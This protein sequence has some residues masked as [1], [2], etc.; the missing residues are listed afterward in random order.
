VKP[1]TPLI[2]ATGERVMAP[3]DRLKALEVAMANLQ[4]KF[5]AD[6]PEVKKAHREITELR[7]MVMQTGGRAAIRRQKI[8]QL[9]AN[10]AEKQ[11][12][13]SAQH[14]EVK[15]LQNEIARLEPYQGTASPRPVA[16]P[17][18]PAYISL[19]TYIKAA[20]NE[21]VSLRTQQAGLKEKLRL[22]RQR[23][24]DAGIIKM[25]PPSTRRS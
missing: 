3:A 15:Q 24:E 9:Q 13:Y 16:E 22:Y 18:N 2:G 1:D 25:P 10:L 5:T 7:K 11:G 6:H 4:S 12:K 23:L 20:E 8:T 14:P 19:T 21:I 17:E